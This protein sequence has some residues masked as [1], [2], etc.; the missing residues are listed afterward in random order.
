MTVKEI[1]KTTSAM[2]GREDVNAYLSGDTEAV[3]ENT[4]PTV[5]VMVNLLNLVIG[6]LAGTFIPM[7]KTETAATNDGKVYYADLI[8]RAL[9]IK[10][11]YDLSGDE[12]SY[13]QSAEFI[14]VNADKVLV[15]YE[16]AP[17][18]YGL[19]DEIG[20]TEKDVTAGALAFGLAAEYSISLGSFDEAVMWHKRYVDSIAEQR[21]L[22]NVT[23]KT[24]SFV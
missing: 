24:R 14:K 15:E 4:L 20:Y 9:E 2:L 18:N 13:K 5:G 11:V 3:G 22:R 16:Y 21:K 10:A 17:P 12:I 8:E 19:E 23:L 7:V 1:L 6:E